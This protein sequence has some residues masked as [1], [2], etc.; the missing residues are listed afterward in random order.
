MRRRAA[1]PRP[2]ATPRRRAAAA[3][4]GVAAAIVAAGTLA[5]SPAQ[6]APP[7]HAGPPEHAGAPDHAGPP[8]SDEAALPDLVTA[9]AIEGHLENLSTIARY[10]GG[11]R[12]SNTPGYDVAAQY[13]EDQL[14]RAGYEPYRHEYEYLDW[15]EHSD[16][17]L[18]TTAPEDAGFELGVDFATMSYSAAGDVTAPGVLVETDAGD[19]GCSPEHFADFPEGAV[20]VT[21]RGAC[22]FADKVQNAADAGAS[23]TVVINNVDE[24][25]QG[26][27]SEPSDIPA[28]G[29][30]QEAGARLLEAGEGLELR[31]VVD[32]TAETSTSYSVLA[33][34][35]GG[36]DDNVVV[37]GGHLDSVEEGPGINDNGSG[38]AFVLE[39]A[40]Q[41]AA[42]EDPNNQVRFA[43]WGTEESGLVG[44]TRYVESLTEEQLDDIALYL[45]FDMIGSHNYA[46]FVLDGRGE[47]PDSSGAPSGSGAIA[48][49]FEEYFEEQGQVSEPGVLSGR[50][51]YQPF[52]LAGVP[53]GGLFSGA[54]G[55]KTEAQVEWYG[56]TA[57]ELF[58]PYYHT[59]D[60]T[61]DKINTDALDEL[62]A[63]G[64]H[65]VEFFADNTLPVNGVAP[66]SSPI[67]SFDRV[68]ADLVR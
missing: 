36:R 9:E 38:T 19:S 22:A 8:R 65:G 52:M 58:D 29:M 62:S 23:A 56:G 66:L 68:G 13:V 55:T 64:A 44:S 49:V 47:L 6:A 43:F 11:N 37:V 14:E 4:A 46:R 42:Q 15:Q 48:Q 60:D 17:V 63:A 30:S 34:T 28:V 39:T 16:A 21:V 51:D 67:V 25:L 24:L 7:D 53:A 12:A 5:A 45:N 41:L 2:T 54:D 1:S 31:L 50:S 59:A 40:I 26:T 3:T 61:L 32:S 35:S 57:G 27:V 18:A 33:E 20:A 10:N